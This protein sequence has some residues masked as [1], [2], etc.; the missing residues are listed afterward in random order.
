MPGPCL[1][2]DNPSTQGQPH[3]CSCPT[4]TKFDGCTSTLH[5]T[6]KGFWWAR[7]SGYINCFICMW[8]NWS[9]MCC[10]NKFPPT[11]LPVTSHIQKSTPRLQGHCH[12]LWDLLQSTNLHGPGLKTCPQDVAQQ[13]LFRCSTS[14]TRQLP[15]HVPS[16]PSCHPGKQSA[17][18]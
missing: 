12:Y 14:S 11:L 9:Q 5:P 18:L 6:Q 7:W 13:S 10:W 8:W 16:H 2:P 3:Y 1:V 17:T 4:H 15:S